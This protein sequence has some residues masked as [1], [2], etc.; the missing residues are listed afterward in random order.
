MVLHGG[1]VV[2]HAG[3]EEGEHYLFFGEGQAMQLGVWLSAEC[4]VVGCFGQLESYDFIVH[5]AE[6]DLVALV[7]V[8]VPCLAHPLLQFLVPPSQD[9]EHQVNAFL[10]LE[11][12]RLI[13]DAEHLLFFHDFIEM[14]TKDVETAFNVCAGVIF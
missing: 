7:F 5:D 10:I 8:A 6:H 12:F 2:I 13:T 1:D 11:V 4:V 14:V 9:L 3:I